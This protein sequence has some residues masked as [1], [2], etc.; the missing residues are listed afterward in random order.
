MSAPAAANVSRSSSGI[1]IMVGPVSMRKPASANT[2][3][4]PPGTS[5]R[6]ST[7]TS[8]PRRTRLAAA[9]RPPRPAPMTTTRMSGLALAHELG[10]RDQLLDRLGSE[11]DVARGRDRLRGER[12]DR[13][14]EVGERA[15]LDQHG[16]DRPDTGI[17]Q[18]GLA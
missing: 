14:L 18:P 9:A 4:L 12:R 10:E 3:A 13:G 17:A 15:G 2:P 5:S 7:V 11:V 1:V 6:S 8:W 16:L